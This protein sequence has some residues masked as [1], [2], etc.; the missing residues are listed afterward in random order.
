MN[1]YG[2][3]L[4]LLILPQIFFYFGKSYKALEINSIQIPLSLGTLNISLVVIVI[5]Y[6]LDKRRKNL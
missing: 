2:Y 1:N 4:S 6:L 3:Y 5:S